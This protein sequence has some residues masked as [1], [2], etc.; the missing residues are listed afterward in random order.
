MLSIA[1]QGTQLRTGAPCEVGRRVVGLPLKSR[2]RPRPRSRRPAVPP[3]PRH[4][5]PLPIISPPDAA[6]VDIRQAHPC[7]R[8]TSAFLHVEAGVVVV[9]KEPFV[10]IDKGVHRARPEL[11]QT[12]PVNDPSVADRR[13]GGGIEIGGFNEGDLGGFQVVFDDG[14]LEVSSTFSQ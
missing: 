7:Q 11:S 3:D 6:A 10:M 14:I 8:P 1:D 12:V 2:L 4:D 5:M 13:L 9:H